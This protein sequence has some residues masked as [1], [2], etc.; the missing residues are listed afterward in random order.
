MTTVGVI[1][2]TH[3]L[4]G[5]RFKLPQI[6]FEKF[7]NV[8]F[9]LHA[10]DLNIMQV[11]TDLEALAPVFAVQGN[12]DRWDVLTALPSTRE[13]RIEL[14]TVGLV[15]G[16]EGTGKSTPAR[17]LSHFPQADCVV[18]GHSH[19]SLID[20]CDVGGRRVLLFNPGSA[21]DKRWGPHLSLGLLR[22][23]GDTVEPELITW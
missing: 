6:V 14:C 17:A 11:V 23:D 9:I 12:N 5:G 20:W 10:G 21:T 3:V 22:I 18:F 19:R 13:M 1:A 15:H 4:P 2:D 8:D 7:A 16:H